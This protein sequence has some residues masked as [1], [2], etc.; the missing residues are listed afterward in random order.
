MSSVEPMTRTKVSYQ[1]ISRTCIVGCYRAE[2][3]GDFEVS[4]RDSC[5]LNG[6]DAGIVICFQNIKVSV[7]E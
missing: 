4:R 2:I 5:I 7:F 3:V 1:V 6:I